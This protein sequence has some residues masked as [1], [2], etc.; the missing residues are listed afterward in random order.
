MACDA[1]LTTI[2]A[3]PVA[4]AKVITPHAG[5]DK[6]TQHKGEKQ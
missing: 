5:I 3:L 2:S 4:A 1:M 6:Y